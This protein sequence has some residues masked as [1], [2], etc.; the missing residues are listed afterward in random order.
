MAKTY[1]A[2]LNSMLIV[3]ALVPTYSVAQ[4]SSPYSFGG[5]CGS[6]GVWTQ[7]ALSQAQRIAEVARNL[8]DDPNC[9]ALGE[10]M[11]SAFS[12]MS[13]TLTP[14]HDTSGLEDRRATEKQELLQIPNNLNALTSTMMSPATPDGMK[15][16]ATPI[17]AQ[18]AIRSAYLYSQIPSEIEK[19]QAPNSVN[20]DLTS[21]IG[22]LQRGADVGL[23][24]LGKV[25][26]D[27]PA[28]AECAA[29][30][31][32]FGQFAAATVQA[33]GAILSSGQNNSGSKTAQLISELTTF[34]R[35]YKFSE[36]IG[37]LNEQEYLTSISCL[38]EVTSENYCSVQDTMELFN[39]ELESFVLRG[40]SQPA[41]RTEGVQNQSEHGILEASEPFQGYYILT[42][43]APNITEWLQLIQIGVDPKLPTDAQFKN[44]ILDEV[45]G[46]YKMT[47]DLLGVYEKESNTV[48]AQSDITTKRN[49]AI[50]MVVAL[51]DTMGSSSWNKTRN[52]FL[53]RI[54]AIHLP[55][56]LIGM[57]IDDIPQAVTRTDGGYR[58]SPDE[59]LKQNGREM[60]E[61]KD[62]DRL[63]EIIG[64]NLRELIREANL[65]VIEYH[66]TWFVVDQIGLVDKSL[67][68]MTYTVKDSFYATAAYLA[69]L[70]ERIRRLGGD[71][72]I[73]I[74][75]VDLRQRIENILTAL[76]DT[77]HIFGLLEEIEQQRAPLLEQYLAA[78]RRLKA[79]TTDE[80]QRVSSQELVQLQQQFQ[81]LEAQLKPLNDE[82]RGMSKVWA[83]IVVKKVYEEFEIMLA[84]SGFLLNRLSTLVYNDY[85][86]QLKSGVKYDQYTTEL[87]TALGRASFDRIL[88]L[89]QGS[90][91][92]IQSDLNLAL[93]I[94]KGN[95]EALEMLFRDKMIGYIANLKM[96]ES[97]VL[98]TKDALIQDARKRAFFDANAELHKY[99]VTITDQEYA[100][101][102]E[103]YSLCALN[104]PCHRY[105]ASFASPSFVGLQNEKD[106]MDAALYVIKYPERYPTP[107]L[108]NLLTEFDKSEAVS[109]DTQ[110]K[111]SAF[112]RGL[113][114]TQSLAFNNWQAFFPICKDAQLE[115]PY[116]KVAPQAFSD[117][118]KS[119]LSVNYRQKLS[120][121]HTDLPLNHSTRICA[122]R[123]F[124]RRNLVQMLLMQQQH[125]ANE[126]AKFDRFNEQNKNHSEALRRY[127]AERASQEQ[128]APATPDLEV[129]AQDLT[130][131][132]E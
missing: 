96:R 105:L 55:F 123:D 12:Q 73:R 69:E 9:T 30:D 1:L 19:S 5:A 91:T 21:A 81:Q 107:S 57:K 65:A 113:Y 4:N 3:T 122:F 92:Q 117:E 24:I 126:R 6:Q 13:Q 118:E 66:N 74:S 121:H 93:R 75:T 99:P 15:A 28:T 103:R 110:Y 20:L 31:Q 58:V 68:S 90:P 120:E 2:I 35:Q 47:N 41:P 115:S 67:T 89:G 23:D 42:Q 78:D 60:P 82:F 98:P 72:T 132:A 8:K 112:L 94:N 129:Q 104:L 17:V 11:R 51:S 33:V 85:T 127:R 64:S 36:V 62:P 95:I 29:N 22:R 76:N 52:F 40:K 130:P 111:S 45:I 84:R 56:I 48:R 26:K 16:A 49:A 10:S 46:F 25:I 54:Q 77:S 63:M 131:E 32:A 79:A 61:F 106:R 70:E 114:C 87:M 100:Q 59:F 128:A 102:Q 86:L 109:P 18:N 7:Q 43:H 34:A 119:Y 101:L 14:L 97:G 116:V 125:I 53:T 80:Q 108:W 27:I 50:N 124:N 39:K 71:Q 44:S 37:K 83:S 88:S 38:L